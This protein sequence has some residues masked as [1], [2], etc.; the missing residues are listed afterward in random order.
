[1]QFNESHEKLSHYGLELTPQ[2]FEKNQHKKVVVG[3]SGGVD[4]SV[5]ALLLH[6]QGYQVVGI[7][8]KNWE[9]ENN[10]FCSS[11]EDYKDV[12][13]VCEKIGIPYYAVNFASTYKEKVFQH[14]LDEY[15]A[16]RTP[17]PDILCNREVKF[18]VFFEQA[19][20]LGADFLATGHYAKIEN[21]AGVAKLYK[22]ADQNKDQSYFLYAIE[23]RILGKVLF[24]LGELEKPMVRK[25]AKD[26]DLATSTKKDSTG[27]CFIGERNFRPFLSQYIKEQQGDFVHYDTGKNLGPHMGQ[28]FYTIGQRKGLGLGGPGGP[29]FVV[30]KDADT[31]TVF[32]AEGDDHPA[33]YGK[34]LVANEI[35]WINQ[36]P[37]FPLQAKAK[38][39]YRQQDQNCTINLNDENELVVDFEKAQRAISIGQSLVIYVGENCVGGATICR[40]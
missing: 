29:W 38:I 34:S 31:N 27:I 36:A 4:S 23:G 9:E 39:R 1:M 2:A 11:E 35:H 33:L 10:E 19:M 22:G 17:N 5:A 20:K 30:G 13:L 24:P 40:L 15:R 18:K 8:M 25:I 6:L 12:A 32:V 21:Q 26:W 37:L 28:C 14:F 16:G 7:F 3:M